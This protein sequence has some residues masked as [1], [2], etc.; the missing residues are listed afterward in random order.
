M[1]PAAADAKMAR[2]LQGV[3]VA[4]VP[5]S[6]DARAQLMRRSPQR[7]TLRLKA[8]LPPWLESRQRAG[9]AVAQRKPARSSP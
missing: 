9:A 2:P 6:A 4:V 5:A 8:T 1:T 7:R 3:D